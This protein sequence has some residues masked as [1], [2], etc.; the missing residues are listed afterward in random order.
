MRM[1]VFFFLLKSAIKD[2][3]EILNNYEKI[4]T[5]VITKDTWTDQNMLLTPTLKT[6]RGKIDEKYS[7]YYQ[8]WHDMKESVVWER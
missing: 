8:L 1:A 6:R 5:I 7:K 3:N 2:I 4:S